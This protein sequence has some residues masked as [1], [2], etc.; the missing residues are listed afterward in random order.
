[1]NTHGA[2]ADPADGT[3]PAG[4]PTGAR[5]AGRTA[6]RTAA[7]LA[8][9]AGTATA[10]GLAGGTP[11]R[12]A[13]QAAA[14]STGSQLT[15]DPS[16]TATTCTQ[17]FTS[18][19]TFNSQELDATGPITFTI[20]GGA[21]GNAENGNVWD[22]GTGGEGG[23]VTTP[24]TIPSSYDGFAMFQLSIG[25]NG[26]SGQSSGTPGGGGTGGG[27]P[28]GTGL[29]DIDGGYG[30]GGGGG[31]GA[32][33]VY[34]ANSLVINSG[35]ASLLGIAPGGGGAAPGETGG[36][37][38]G[39]GSTSDGS[40]DLVINGSLGSG[41]F[42]NNPGY[43]PA[44]CGGAAASSTAGGQGGCTE[45]PSAL[46]GNGKASTGGAGSSIN[47]FCPAPIQACVFEGGSPVAGGGGGGGGLYGG[48]GGGV[49][50]VND[51]IGTQ[52]AG[53]GGAGSSNLPVTPTTLPPEVIV[54]W[55]P[56]QAQT[57]T[58]LSLS[59]STVT[60]GT[61]VTATAR[62]TVPGYFE[63][64]DA[65]SIQ[66]AVD[67]W[68]TGAPVPVS[69]DGTASIVLPQLWAGIAD[70]T[71]SYTP[72]GGMSYL[73]SDSSGAA[74]LTVT[75]QSSDALSSAL[76]PGQLLEVNGSNGGVDIWQQVNQG[77]TPVANEQWAFTSVGTSG[78][79]YL[80]NEWTG[81]CLEVNGTTGAVDTW[82]CV[83]GAANELWSE[84]PDP[85]DPAA[86]ELQVQS[87]GEYLGLASGAT[88]N[89][90][91]VSVGQLSLLSFWTVA[92]TGTGY[93]G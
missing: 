59:Q 18:S 55:T 25:G 47:S 2:T 56:D 61:S 10:T 26:G 24:Y 12:A 32:T 17:T 76:A 70:V 79:G 53:G 85:A 43:G 68:N 39:K 44:Y 5:R 82:A 72:S 29:G 46:G 50:L 67:G 80:V 35:D 1:M 3:F 54:S 19:G 78:Y 27:A 14:S 23:E 84:V 62:A 48:G 58:T 45:S 13:T 22:G 64:A 93:P 15:I 16:C 9:L 20:A 40:G 41:N 28:G 60:G 66:F 36:E 51:T 4:R 86:G 7:V 11:A 88:G 81:N 73:L 6:L 57:Q 42:S 49:E 77:G 52:S 74:Q 38:G 87:S 71:A 89:G 65:G 90:A 91:P 37:A 83:P 33:S 92:N 75:A 30:G 63:Q 21:G 69:G 34:V 8:I 31:G